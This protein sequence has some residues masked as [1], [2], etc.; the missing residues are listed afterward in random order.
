[1]RFVRLARVFLLAVALS[2]PFALGQL[3]PATDNHWQES[4]EQRS[5]D[6]PETKI[7][8][9]AE[10]RNLKLVGDGRLAD[11]QVSNIEPTDSQVEEYPESIELQYQREPINSFWASRQ[12]SKIFSVLAESEV[13]F[14]SLTVE[15]RSSICRVDIVFVPPNPTTTSDKLF[16]DTMQALEETFL[17]EDTTIQGQT[18]ILTDSE[19]FSLPTIT[20]FL[21]GNFKGTKLTFGLSDV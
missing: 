5:V 6:S 18:A 3:I 7:D 11:I 12:E 8:I 1:M 4:V 10:S 20:V 13:R 9:N 21:H 17:L 14:A 16:V 15:C 19:V 2:A